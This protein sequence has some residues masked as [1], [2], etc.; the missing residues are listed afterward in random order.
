MLPSPSVH[1]SVR[2]RRILSTSAGAWALLAG[3]PV[4][5][6]DEVQ[7]AAAETQVAAATARTIEEV[8]V[9]ARRREEDAQAVPIPL[10]VLNA[11]AVADAGAFNVNRLKE[12]IPSVQF[13]SS[14]PRNSTLNIRGI[15][16]PFGLTND[17]LELGVGLYVDGVYYARPAAATLDFID[18]QQI[19]VLRGPQ[20]CFTARTPRPVRST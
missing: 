5:A 3:L 14:N 15:G 19:E 17:G 20:G 6:A 9:T 13:Y 12:L 18:V 4:L 8:T 10:T 2:L 16:A 1:R 11:D 7:V